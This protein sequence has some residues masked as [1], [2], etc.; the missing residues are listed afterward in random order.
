MCSGRVIHFDHNTNPCVIYKLSTITL[1]CSDRTDN[2]RLCLSNEG[3]SIIIMEYVYV[4][5]K[6]L[7]TRVVARLCLH[8]QCHSIPDINGLH[9]RIRI[10]VRTREESNGAGGGLSYFVVKMVNIVW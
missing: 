5:P 2:F 1:H 6:R 8:L 10:S 7:I 3:G 9:P 4:S